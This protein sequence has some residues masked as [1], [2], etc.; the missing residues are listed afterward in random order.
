VLLGTNART[1]FDLRMVNSAG[2]IFNA[3]IEMALAENQ[4]G[5]TLHR[6]VISDITE[7]T[8]AEETIKALLAEKELILREVHHR[9]KNNMNTMR[10]LLSLQARRTG[11]A[12]TSAA[13]DDAAKRLVSMEV[14]YDKL[15][16]STGFSDLSVAQYLQALVDAVLSNFPGYEAIAV[17]KQFEDF[18]LDAKRL[19]PLGIIV[20]ELLTNAMRYAFKGKSDGRLLVSAALASGL[21][22]IVVQDNGNGIPDSVELGR[23]TGFGLMLVHELTQQLG[24]SIRI[25]RGGGTRI[26]LEFRL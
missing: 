8:R 4:N 16:R 2:G 25:E 21:A 19:Q 6:V 12:A 23:S 15:Y 10:S 3:R 17:E 20:N 11:D 1:G 22:A 9:I 26:V 7:R 13:L 24:G 5:E 18:I 14:L